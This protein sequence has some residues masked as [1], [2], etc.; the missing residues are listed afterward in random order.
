MAQLLKV[1][2]IRTNQQ[3]SHLTGD[4]VTAKGI[5]WV[6]LFSKTDTKA[7]EN[8][9]AYIVPT[10]LGNLPKNKID[11]NQWS[12][13]TRLR[14]A[15]NSFN[16]PGPIDLVLGA[17]FYSRVIE[18]GVRKSK[19][20]PTAQKT[21]FGWIVFGGY[22]ES[23]GHAS[24]VNVTQIDVTNEQLLKMLTKFWKYDTIFKKQ[25][26]TQQ[27]Q[28]C[29]DIFTQSIKVTKD[30]RYSARMPLKSN[31]PQITGTYEL[32]YA[33]QIQMEKRFAREPKL[34]ENY[35]NF[36]QEYLELNHMRPVP[37]NEYQSDTAVYI[38]HHAAQSEKF[39]TVFDGS[40]KKKGNIS[41]NDI[42]LN[43]EKRQPDL[44]EILM[45][46]RTHQFTLTSDIKKM[47]RQTLI[48]EDQQDANRILWRKS[49]KQPM[50]EYRLITHMG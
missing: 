30:G 24:I 38:P 16:V 9:G 14:L 6:D 5:A 17:D 31:A 36:M 33:R 4:I 35:I 48:D 32:A 12:H 2:K 44:I 28:Q 25:Y 11:I 22:C 37:E 45:R 8:I 29:E 19:G 26:R 34:K 7:I 40:C 42:Q 39:R 13:L 47:Y 43:G 1:N 10:M 23:L 41:I 50:R 49:P 15:D 3:I 20:A 18:N 27:Q 46:F 21:C